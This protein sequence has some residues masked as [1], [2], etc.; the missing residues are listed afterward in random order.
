MKVREAD[1]REDRQVMLDLLHESLPQHGGADHFDWLYLRNPAGE[2][3]AWLAEDQVG[4][5]IGVAAAGRWLAA[6]SRI[7]SN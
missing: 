1:L 5:P 2:A 6:A 3:R 7:T 4:E